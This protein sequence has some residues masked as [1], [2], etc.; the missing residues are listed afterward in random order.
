MDEDA[1]DL[2]E[3]IEPF[4]F[5]RNSCDGRGVDVSIESDD[6]TFWEFPVGDLINSP[7]DALVAPFS[8]CGTVV[9]LGSSRDAAS[10]RKSPTGLP[11]FFFGTSCNLN[12]SVCPR[13]SGIR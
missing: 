12:L 3:S 11:D 13:A 6:A 7:C 2:E 5:K 9:D 1:P 8:S 4:S 10:S